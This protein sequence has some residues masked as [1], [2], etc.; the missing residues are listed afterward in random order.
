MNCRQCE[1][2]L[3]EAL[4]GELDPEARRRFDIHLESCDGCAATYARMQSTLD[5][6]ERRE[7]PDPGQAYWDGFFNR[8]SARMEREAEG[9]RRRGW[10]GRLFP[11]MPDTTVRWAYRGVVAA[12]LIIFGAV[13]GRVLIPGTETGPESVPG[14]GHRVAVTENGGGDGGK[15]VQ[16]AAEAC[17]RQYIEDSQVLLLALVRF[18]PGTELEY[19]SDWSA[20]KKRSRELVSQAASLKESLNDPG[21]RRLRELVKELE[22]I[23]MQ[24]ANI[25]SAA[26]LESVE[27]IRSSVNDRDVML[28]I[29]LEKLR[30]GDKPAADPGSCDA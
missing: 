7:Q 8:V 20:E 5:V 4:Y 22:L 19:L 27:L 21:Q 29:N 6:M 28:K 26:D 15:V 11:S 18:D 16:T 12:V 9:R 3:V 30:G 24:I 13:A 1:D 14:G 10:L 2:L 23:M 25:E 17:A